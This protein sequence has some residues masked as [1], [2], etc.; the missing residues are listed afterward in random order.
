MELV[1]EIINGLFD[2]LSFDASHEVRYVYIVLYSLLGAIIFL[3][4]FKKTS[5][6]GRIKFHKDKIW[7]YILQIRLYKDSFRLLLISIGNILKHNCLYMKFMIIPLLAIMVPLLILTTQINNRYGYEPLQPKQTFIITTRLADN[8]DTNQLFQVFCK[9]S[10][11]IILETPPIRM[12]DELQV[13]WRARATQPQANSQPVIQIGL[14]GEPGIAEKIVAVDYAVKRFCP[15]LMK[16][17]FLD[18]LIYNAEGFLNAD[19]PVQE[20]NIRY[21]R[22]GYGFVFI[23]M[24]PIILFFILT[25]CFALLFKP[26]FRVQF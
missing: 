21:N 1:L 26:F 8:L 4:L 11:G 17:S 20:I 6:Q 22:A 14:E 15:T 10:P 7:G 3:I 18:G 23:E 25:L 12:E 19:S 2:W 13:S 5:N 16:L 24:D 9:V